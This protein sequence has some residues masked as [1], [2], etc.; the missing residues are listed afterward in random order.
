MKPVRTGL[1]FSMIAITFAAALSIRSG[2]AVPAGP[3]GKFELTSPAFLQDGTI[4]KEFTCE[5]AN[6]SPALKWTAPP[7]NT[8]S[9]ALIVDDPDAPAGT[10]VHWMIFNLPA[11]DRELTAAA[12]GD[13]ELANG[14]RQGRN[15]FGQTAYG[16]P[17]P[18][19]GPAHRYFFKLYA[20]DVKLDLKAGAAKADLEKAM[21]GHIL[22]KAELMARYQRSR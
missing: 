22:G 11:T 2:A 15:D 6:Q 21:Q 20:L 4:P 18:P 1:F 8:K 10:W 7:A 5:G 13:P 19:P 12:P 3:A 9:L 16:G 14:A 17:C